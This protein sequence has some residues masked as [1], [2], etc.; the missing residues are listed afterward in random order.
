M[1]RWLGR[2]LINAQPD[3][4]CGEFEHREIVGGELFVARGDSAEAF[5]PVEETFDTVALA[6]EGAAEAVPLLAVAPIGDV[7]R[8]ALAF[9]GDQRLTLV[10]ST[11]AAS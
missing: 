2:G 4:R 1:T 7:G 8:G 3:A 11:L 10:S 5:D 9:S 6:V